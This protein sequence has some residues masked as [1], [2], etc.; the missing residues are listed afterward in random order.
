MAAADPNEPPAPPPPPNV[1][2]LAPVKPSEFAV[3]GD[4][5]YAFGR[6]TG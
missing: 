4:S 5:A 2:A 6:P 3:L 1:N